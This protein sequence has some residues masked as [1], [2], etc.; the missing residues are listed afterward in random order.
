MKINNP[1]LEVDD[2][3]LNDEDFITY[4]LTSIKEIE[5]NYTCA[6]TEASNE[7]LF[8]QYK[9]MHDKYISLQREIYE[10]MFRKGFYTLE[11][12][13]AN[14]ISEKY[15]TLKQKYSSIN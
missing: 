1:K 3:V 10:V 6:L 13:E 15:N 2:K 11:T 14:K 12:L 9:I 8:N 7:Y 5:K 4:L